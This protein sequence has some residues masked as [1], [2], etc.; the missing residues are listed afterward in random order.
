MPDLKIEYLLLFAGF[1]LPGA[2]SMYVYGLKVGQKEHQLNERILEAIWFSILNFVAL[3]WLIQFLFRPDFVLNDP[4]WTWIIV[5]ACFVLAPIFWPF[6]LVWLLR[7]AQRWNWIRVRA[8]TAWDD[9]FGTDRRGIWIQA[10][11]HDEKVVGGRFSRES[12]ASA[13]PEPG[14][15][16]IQELWEVDAQGRFTRRVAGEAGILLRPAD[17]KYIRV[18]LGD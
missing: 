5:L 11:L 12:Y 16:F 7:R 1:V 14:H 13:Y 10:V 2:I 4:L 15:L 8:P 18:Y 6:A 3:I 9:F 17:Y